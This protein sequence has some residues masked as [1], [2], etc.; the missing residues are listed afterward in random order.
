M[1]KLI[2][3]F[4]IMM[5]NILLILIFIII[6]SR[7]INSFSVVKIQRAK[8][9]VKKSAY[10]VLPK[11]INIVISGLYVPWTVTAFQRRII[12]DRR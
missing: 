9:D 10:S 5:T 1:M 6:K 7:N 2:N 3:F 12:I 8:T 11:R 4:I